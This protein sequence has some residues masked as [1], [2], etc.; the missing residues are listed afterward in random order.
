[1]KISPAVL[2]ELN[3]K[4][5]TKNQC[6]IGHIRSLMQWFEV[7]RCTHISVC[8]KFGMTLFQF[9]YSQTLLN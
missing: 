6:I 4:I 7:A 1:M 3:L 9:V 2:K 8:G 5:K